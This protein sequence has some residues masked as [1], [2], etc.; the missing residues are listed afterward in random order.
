MIRLNLNCNFEYFASR[1]TCTYISY[2]HFFDI[3]N[4]INT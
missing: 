1:H 3:I 2:F 4:A